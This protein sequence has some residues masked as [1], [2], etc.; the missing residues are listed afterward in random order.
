MVL[1]LLPFSTKVKTRCVSRVM[2]YHK[3]S[4]QHLTTFFISTWWGDSKNVQEIS[5]AFWGQTKN[6]TKIAAGLAW[7]AVQFAGC[8]KSHR[9]WFQYLAFSHQVDMKNV[10]NCWKYFLWYSNN[11][12][13][14]N[15]GL[16]L[17]H[18]KELFLHRSITI[19]ARLGGLYSPPPSFWP[20]G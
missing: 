4:F 15:E 7:L 3:K 11:L 19:E 16:W 18:S 9:Y 14:Y 20:N 12:E 1:G 5:L 2:E 13:I 8:A 6:E 17:V 10:V